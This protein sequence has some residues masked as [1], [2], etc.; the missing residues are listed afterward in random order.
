MVFFNLILYLVFSIIKLCFRM[1]ISGAELI[2]IL[3]IFINP[4]FVL[5]VSYFF[6]LILRKKHQLAQAAIISI[7]SFL[8]FVVFLRS[9]LIAFGY[10]QVD[11]FDSLLAIFMIYPTN[12][13]VGAVEW[14]FLFRRYQVWTNYDQE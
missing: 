10:N 5:T 1:M 8:G 12:G 4:F 6:T 13:L 9:G 7:S 2:L 3:W 11:F 14:G